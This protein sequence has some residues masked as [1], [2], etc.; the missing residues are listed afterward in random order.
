MDLSNLILE[1]VNNIFR[2]SKIKLTLKQ[3]F[4]ANGNVSTGLDRV[5]AGD[6]NFTNILILGPM[7]NIFNIFNMLKLIL[8]TLISSE[9][10]KVESKNRKVDFK[11][12]AVRPPTDL[13]EELVGETLTE[14]SVREEEKV[15]E[16][17]EVSVDVQVYVEVTQNALIHNLHSVNTQVY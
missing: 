12:T 13:V 15:L 7:N 14:L 17:S 11:C 2:D 4:E 3:H 1:A 10:L 8:N 6:F 16:S 5:L 9:T